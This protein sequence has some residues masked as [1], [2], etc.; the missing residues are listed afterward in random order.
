MWA[1][2][3]VATASSS[4]QLGRGSGNQRNAG[5]LGCSRLAKSVSSYGLASVL[6]SMHPR[7]LSHTLIMPPCNA[8]RRSHC[9]RTGTHSFAWGCR[10]AASLLL[11]SISAGRSP[12]VISGHEA[13]GHQTTCGG[14]HAMQGRCAPEKT[15][16]SCIFFTMPLISSTA[17]LQLWKC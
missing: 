13:N 14:L 15:T 8:T 17:A 2:M 12:R 10:V 11:L 4:R 6:L 7:C 5:C 1:L 3:W 9:T 16:F